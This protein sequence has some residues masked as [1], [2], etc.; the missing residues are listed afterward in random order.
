M[1][2]GYDY[3]VLVKVSEKNA[4]NSNDDILTSMARCGPDVRSVRDGGVRGT[5]VA[6][7]ESAD[8]VCCLMITFHR[9]F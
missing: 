2:L 4:P 3:F 1:C 5:A 7:V 6:S 8:P 9:R